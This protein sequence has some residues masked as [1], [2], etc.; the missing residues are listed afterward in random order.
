MKYLRIIFVIGTVFLFTSIHF[1]AFAQNSSPQTPPDFF[2]ELETLEINQTLPESLR[3]QAIVAPNLNP[4]FPNREILTFPSTSSMHPY[5]VHIEKGKIVFIQLAVRKEKQD[6]YTYQL[7]SMGGTRTEL[8]KSETE[9]LVGFPGSGVAY[10]VTGASNKVIRV[11][12]FSPK[13]EELFI[14]QEGKYFKPID[15]QPLISSNKQISENPRFQFLRIGTS[16]AIVILIFFLCV[17]TTIFFLSRKR[18]YN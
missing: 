10:V 17:F 1:V 8:A 11:L 2:M 3:T 9:K 4:D 6:Y 7:L 18:K 13:T 14:S 15:V 16:I 12:K 5:V